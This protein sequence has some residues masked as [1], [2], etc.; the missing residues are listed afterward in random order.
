MVNFVK[1]S[2]LVFLLLVGVHANAEKEK[3][4]VTIESEQYYIIEDLLRYFNEIAVLEDRERRV[5]NG[6]SDTTLSKM[7][8]LDTLP[9]GIKKAIHVYQTVVEKFNKE[10]ADIRNRHKKTIEIAIKVLEMQDE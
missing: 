2:A 8:K 1:K 4:Y 10:Y 6:F 3:K 9:E 7:S 5:L